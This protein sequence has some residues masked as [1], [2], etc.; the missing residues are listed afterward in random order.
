MK[1]YKIYK[2]Q[3]IVGKTPKGRDKKRYIEVKEEIELSRLVRFGDYGLGQIENLEARVKTLED[4]IMK[5][6]LEKPEMFR[7]YFEE[8]VQ[9]LNLFNYDA[10]YEIE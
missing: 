3:T 2:K 9:E 8:R 10:R 1:I 4:I 7:S 5:I 6:I